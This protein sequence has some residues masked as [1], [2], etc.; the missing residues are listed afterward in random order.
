MPVTRVRCAGK[1]EIRKTLAGNIASAL[2]PLHAVHMC[3]HGALLVVARHSILTVRVVRLALAGIAS[4]PIAI[5]ANLTHIP[6]AVEARAFLPGPAPET[7]A[8]PICPPRVTQVCWPI[9]WLSHIA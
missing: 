9:A 8:A 1:P 3:P 4:P 2:W 7:P 6:S 5:P